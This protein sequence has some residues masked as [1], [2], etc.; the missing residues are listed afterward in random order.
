MP[1]QSYQ[2]TARQFE[3]AAKTAQTTL[4]AA[5]PKTLAMTAIAPELIA[6]VDAFKATDATVR[7]AFA[8]AEREVKEALTAL[9]P[10]TAAYESCRVVLDA[11]LGRSL[12]SAKTFATPDDLLRAAEALE[13]ELEAQSADWAKPLLTVLVPA[14]ETAS[15]EQAESTTAL[16]ALQKAQAARES[17]A[18]AA[19]PLFVAFRRAVRAELGS[20]A[21][22]YRELADRRY[23][24]TEP[25]TDG[26][27]DGETKTA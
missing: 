9:E 8:A 6:A 12:P 4:S 2:H 15:R 21:R 14:L 19:R 23:A 24:E 13:D 5:Q 20:S 22:E 17:A 3:R 26:T 1:S 25:T 16:K 7:A 10:L 18:G 27:A 11:K